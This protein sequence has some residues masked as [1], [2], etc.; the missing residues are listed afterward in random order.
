VTEVGN[1]CGV[2]D[3]LKEDGRGLLKAQSRHSPRETTEI[4]TD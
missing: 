2:D 4:V 1:E 3:N